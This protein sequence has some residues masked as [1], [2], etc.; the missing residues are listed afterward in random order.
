MVQTLQST[1]RSQYNKIFFFSY[2]TQRYKN[3]KVRNHRYQ[4]K[5]EILLAFDYLTTN[6]KNNFAVV[7]YICIY[8]YIN[9]AYTNLFFQLD[10]L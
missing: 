3:Y 4:W 5:N 8:A 10:I 6:R 7:Y 2:V 1:I 9:Y